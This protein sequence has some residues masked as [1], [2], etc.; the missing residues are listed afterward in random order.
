MSSGLYGCGKCAKDAP[1]NFISINNKLPVIDY[2]N[3]INTHEPMEKYP[4]GAII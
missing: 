4:T 2:D 1:T 3:Y